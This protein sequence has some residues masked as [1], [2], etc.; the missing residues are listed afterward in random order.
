[1][2]PPRFLP[3]H[4]PKFSVLLIMP[5][6]L[7]SSARLK[8]QT[9]PALQQT[10]QLAT[11][12][13]FDMPVAGMG[14][15]GS[16]SSREPSELAP[17]VIIT[18]PPSA[19]ALKEHL[20]SRPFSSYAVGVK[21]DTL[22]IGIESATPLAHDFNLR[23]GT[24]FFAYGY[25]FQTNGVRYNA[26]L[27]FRSAQARLDWFPW[28][29][30]FH[31]SPGILYFRNSMTAVATVP[32]GQPFQLNDQN[33]IN[34]V[35]DPVH[36]SAVVR[37]PHR[38][39][40]MLTV[41]FGNLLPRSGRHFSVPFEIGAAFVGTMKASVELSGTAC[42]TDGCVNM[43]TDPDTQNDLKQ[44]LKDVNDT[45]SSIP[46]YPIVSIGFSYRF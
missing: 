12:G 22:G 41:G 27:D 20:S 38:V 25:P 35:N 14:Y 39:A 30:W 2:L 36:G 19:Q 21:A 32:P 45:L 26:E 1:M 34:S 15:R 4:T 37:V 23:I 6:L 7:L 28:H 11:P 33:F 3:R 5:V 43:A 16:S 9:A 40:P 24:D 13:M 46:I 29:N 8:G 10:A 18:A 31:V 44:E 42:T 17:E